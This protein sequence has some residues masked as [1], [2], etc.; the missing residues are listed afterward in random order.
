MPTLS[1]FPYFFSHRRF[2]Y[3]GRSGSRGS[4]F[5]DSPGHLDAGLP[6]QAGYINMLRFTLLTFTALAFCITLTVALLPPPGNRDR[7]VES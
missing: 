2:H 4:R 1:A 7:P 6:S 3:L 5:A